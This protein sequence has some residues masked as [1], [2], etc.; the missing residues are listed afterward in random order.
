[1]SRDSGILLYFSHSIWWLSRI[2]HYWFFPLIMTESFLVNLRLTEALLVSRSISNGAGSSSAGA[3]P[4]SQQLFRRLSEV[5]SP[6]PAS[7]HVCPFCC[8]P[9]LPQGR[10][11]LPHALLGS[12]PNRLPAPTSLPYTS[13]EKH[14]H[15]AILRTMDEQAF[16][17]H[18]ASSLPLPSL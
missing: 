3:A 5:V 8:F 1:M 17:V 14:L 4:S 15:L 18:M 10:T 16:Q 7:S 11:T 6:V 12:F 13:L 9:Y 2:T